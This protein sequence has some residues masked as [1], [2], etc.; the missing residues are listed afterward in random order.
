[1][2]V[3]TITRAQAEY[4]IQATRMHLPPAVLYC[5]GRPLADSLS[6]PR[7]AIVGSRRVTAYGR[8]VTRTLARE[9]AGQGVVIISGLAIGVDAEAHAAA[10]RA[11]GTTIAVLPSPVEEPVP[12]TNRRL[13]LD[14]LNSGGTLVSTYPAGSQNYRENFVARNELVAALSDA[15]IVTEAATR[16]GTLRTAAFAEDLSVPVFA[17]PGAITSPLSVGTHQL[18]KTN[19]AELLSSVEDVLRQLHLAVNAPKR[20][21][22]KDPLQQCLLDLLQQGIAEGEEL[23]IRSKLSVQQ[24]NQSLTLLEIDGKVLPLGA[25][26]WGLP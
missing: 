6:R 4:P 5:R 11:G 8:Q 2:E 7:V 16:S 13:A 10:L 25:N 20:L 1:M 15:I 21:V 14:I 26:R 9:L 12:F 17:V 24:F 3:T 22:A 23:L 18:I 19:R